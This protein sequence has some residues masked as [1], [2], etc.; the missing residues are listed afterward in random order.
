MISN[1][2]LI[3]F[4]TSH[5]ASSYR[6]HI[7]YTIDS[8][9][10]TFHDLLQY[11]FQCTIITMNITLAIHTDYRILTIQFVYNKQNLNNFLIYLTIYKD[12][13]AVTSH[14]LQLL[15]VNTN[16]IASYIYQN[17]NKNIHC[18]K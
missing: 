9:I 4:E 11:Q 10:N 2:S 8:T 7:T 5:G 18:T 12:K 14:R 16:D 15:T 3:A 17:I 6:P 1:H 13:A